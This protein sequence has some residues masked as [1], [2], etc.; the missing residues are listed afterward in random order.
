MTT[1]RNSQRSSRALLWLLA[2]LVAAGGS[3]VSAH[4]LDEF[5]QAARIAVEPDRVLLD[6]S[7]TPGTAVA[8][9]V[10]S[11]IDINRDSAFSDAEKQAYVVR[12]LGALILQ[13]DDGP[14]LPLAILGA[15]VPDAAAMR[16]G[17]G[18]ILVHAEATGRRWPAGVHQ[19][20]FRNDHDPATSVY[21]ANALVPD[22]DAVMV[23]A[24][25]RN[26]DQR[27]LTIVFAVAAEEAGPSR[28]PW[29]GLAGMLGACWLLGRV[30]GHR[31]LHA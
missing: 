17:D 14:R 12:A 19:L 25:R 2:T 30:G 3:R 13:V 1:A 5:L 18:V 23:T 29:L 4:R 21:L 9:R 6:M 26:A 15:T 10:I 16:T 11:D 24:Q 22:S 20:H 27:A 28:W 8:Q 31:R 7:L